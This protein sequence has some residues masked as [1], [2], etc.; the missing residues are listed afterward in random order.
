MNA[1]LDNLAA[2]EERLTKW[3]NKW[4][5]MRYLNERQDAILLVL[6]L[7]AIAVNFIPR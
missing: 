7:T 1:F 6:I 3:T 5:P 2:A 4:A